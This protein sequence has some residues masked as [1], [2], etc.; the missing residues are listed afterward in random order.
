[1]LRE[2]LPFRSRFLY[3]IYNEPKPPA[4]RAPRPK[5]LFSPSCGW[6]WNIFTIRVATTMELA[7]IYHHTPLPIIYPLQRLSFSFFF[8]NSQFVPSVSPF[9]VRLK[10]IS[11]TFFRLPKISLLPPRPCILSYVFG[12]NRCTSLGSGLCLVACAHKFSIVFGFVEWLLCY[13][14]FAGKDFL[15]LLYILECSSMFFSVLI[16]LFWLKTLIN[17]FWT[18]LF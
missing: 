5:L 10:S 1:V 15:M 6:Y 16:T 3:C 14:I 13:C 12:S 4:T 8:V 11:C 18:S 9:L 17:Q 2:A 7:K